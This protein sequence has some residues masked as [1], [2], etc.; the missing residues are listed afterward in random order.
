MAMNRVQ[1]QPGLSM[2]KFLAR[3]D[4]E[5]KCYRSLYKAR[6]P[7]GFRCPCCEGRARSRFRRDGRVYY[8]CRAPATDH[9]H[10]RH[11]VRGLE[12]AADHVVP[13]DASADV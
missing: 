6:W 7:R 10:Q 13:G 1:F 4:T 9:A 2:A 11:A 8:Q 3:Y 12:G 5:A